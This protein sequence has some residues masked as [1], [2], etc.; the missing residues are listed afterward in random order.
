[1]CRERLI[2]MKHL[3]LYIVVTRPQSSHLIFLFVHIAV[4]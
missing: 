4:E 3:H 2:V 1:M